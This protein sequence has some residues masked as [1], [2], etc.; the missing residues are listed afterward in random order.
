VRGESGRHLNRGKWPDG[1]GYGHRAASETR[2]QGDVLRAMRPMLH[3]DS[4]RSVRNFLCLSLSSYLKEGLYIVAF[5]MAGCMTSA[6]TQNT[7]PINKN[8]QFVVFNQFI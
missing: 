3:A 2:W 7:Y 5:L 8:N 1:L 6:E 4:R